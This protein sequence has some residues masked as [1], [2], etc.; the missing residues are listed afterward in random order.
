MVLTCW[1][2]VSLSHIGH[3]K[4]LRLWVNSGLITFGLEPYKAWALALSC[5]CSNHGA[6]HGAT[7]VL[8]HPRAVG[9]VT[10]VL[11]LVHPQALAPRAVTPP[12]QTILQG[13]HWQS[14]LSFFQDCCSSTSI[15][16]SHWYPLMLQLINLK[17]WKLELEVS[18]YKWN[19]CPWTLACLPHWQHCVEGRF[20]VYMERN[21]ILRMQWL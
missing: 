14:P 1:S 16:T 2:W 4:I 11:H 21:H 17:L 19:F 10:C 18:L 5:Q 7:H 6:T 13:W 12:A 15:D 20:A 9:V 3:R 8:Q